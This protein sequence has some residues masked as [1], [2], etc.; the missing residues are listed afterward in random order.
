MIKRGR[1]LPSLQSIVITDVLTKQIMRSMA[2]GSF[3][4]QTGVSQRLERSNF[5]RSI[6]HLRNVVSP[7]SASQS[8]FEA[9]ELHATHWGRLC[10]VRTPEGQNIGLRKFLAL[11]SEITTS[12]DDKETS[13]VKETLESHGVK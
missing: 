6:E 12:M 9:R 13:K 1:R 2:V 5:T 4:D 11:G 7:L 10:I 8:H 3:K